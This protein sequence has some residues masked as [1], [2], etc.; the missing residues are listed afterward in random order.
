TQLRLWA[1]A[2]PFPGI[3][4]LALTILPISSTIKAPQL[5]VHQ[6]AL[7]N[8][9]I[10]RDYRFI[11]NV[12][13][14]AAVERDCQGQ[15]A[16]KT[17]K[18]SHLIRP[19]AHLLDEPSLT[20]P[21]YN[22]RGNVFINMQ[23][24]PHAR[25]TGRNNIFSGARGLVLGDYPVYYKQ[26]RNLAV[27]VEDPPLYER[28]VIHADK[29][30]DRA[31]LR[32]FSA[33]T[34]QKLTENTEGSMGLIVFLFVIGEL[35]DAYESRTMMHATRAK[36]ALRA[37]LF[38]T[39]WKLFLRKQGYSLGRNYISA[40]AD[41]I[42]DMLIDGLLGII[43]IH[44]DHLS[45]SN[46]PLLP[47]KHESMGNERIFV[48]LRDLFPDMSLA[49][50]MFALPHI[51][52]SARGYSFSDT[53]DD[54]TIC[55]VHLA[56]FPSDDELTAL[57]GEAIEE[58]NTLW[59]LLNVNI[60]N[61]TVAPTVELT[62]APINQSDNPDH[63]S[64]EEDE[65]AA[66]VDLCIRD[67]LQE[68]LVAVEDVV[69]LLRSEENEIDACAYAAAALVV[70]NL[71]SIDNLPQLDDPAQLELCRQDVARILKSA[72]KT[73][74][75]LISGLQTSF[76]GSSKPPLVLIRQ[77][78]QTED[79]HKGVR[80]FK[81]GAATSMVL[82]ADQTSKKKAV[83]PTQKQ[84]LARR[85]QAVI[86]DA[87]IRKATTGLNRKARTEQPEDGAV[88]TN[89]QKTTA[90]NAA[91][92]A[93]AAEVRASEAT[94]RR[95]NVFKDLR[96]KSDVSSAGIGPLTPLG[97]NDF[98]F[99]IEAGTILLA[100]VITL[101]SKGAG[102]GGKHDY[103]SSVDNVGRVSYAFVQTYA[104][105]TGR[106]YQRLHSASA[107]LNIS[108][109][110]HLPAGSLLFRIPDQVHLKDSVVTVSSAMALK[111]KEFQSEQKGLV[112][113]VTTL[114][115]VQRCGKSNINVVDLE[116]ENDVDS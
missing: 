59:S 79:A 97:E 105:R 52:E 99:V 33:A 46:V 106:M 78:N 51:R 4:P 109:F 69:R 73:V 63:L 23:D 102:K 13:D 8:G 100:R 50:V 44:R 61:L 5:V 28:D 68:A 39:T 74:A 36:A 27:A 29:Q 20:V 40:A 98:L 48:A 25:K 24:A 60:Y 89:T 64:E 94:K 108:Q 96:C 43:L 71:M 12:A 45:K 42:Y 3:P 72:P 77:Q 88:A 19:P 14:G 17:I 101:Y 49:Q 21:L 55:F 26:L 112:A 11:S 53:S 30:D 85:I 82:P 34:L 80:S 87:N 114:N 7:L 103:V 110:A 31:A 76:G 9:L 111:Y 95:G 107:I 32:V 104:H 83:E 113:G 75:T 15:V 91:N 58:N 93:A 67:E 6:L 22:L 38:F 86:R 47:W 92:A 84:I 81:A 16:A 57:Y 18:I 70:D 66:I 41:A 62:A 54:K 56:T 2:I 37:R 35:I 116:E 90:G 1:A 65:G 115:T 10:D